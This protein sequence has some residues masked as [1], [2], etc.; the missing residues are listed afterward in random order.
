MHAHDLEL[1]S[2]DSTSTRRSQPG[3]ASQ[4]TATVV[5]LEDGRWSLTRDGQR[6]DAGRA[7]SCLLAPALGDKVWFVAEGDSAY[8]LAVLERAGEGPATL[9]IDGDAELRAEGRLTVSGTELELRGE[10]Q[11]GLQAD[12]LR[13]R[14]RLGKLLLD[15]GS[16]VLRSLFTHVGKSTFVAKVIERFSERF[17]SHSKTSLRSVDEIDQVQAGNIDYRAEEAMQV[18][19][20]HA[21]IKGGELVKVDGG[22]IHL[23]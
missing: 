22:Q 4:G 10:Q 6:F 3:A 11:L 18:T 9:H 2:D 5:A 13:V 20:R 14:G 15:E 23:G 7:A 1:V 8:V 19:A 21:M 17:S 12:E 16:M